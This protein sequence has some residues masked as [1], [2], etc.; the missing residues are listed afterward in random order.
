MNKKGILAAIAVLAGSAAVASFATISPGD[1]TPAPA[2]RPLVESLAIDPE[3]A[4]LA[5]PASYVREEQLHRGDTLAAF[6]ARLGIEETQIAQLAR[7]RALRAL[8]PGISVRAEVAADGSALSLSFL[9]GRD[10]LVTIAPEGDGFAASEA[11]APFET[12]VTMKSSSIRSS[13]FEA[14]D[15]AGV[16]DNIAMQLADVFAGD[17]DFYRDLRKGD[18][19]TVVYETYLLRGRPVR[20]GRLLAAEFV[21][22]GRALRAIHYQSGYYTPEGKNLR[23]AFLRYPLEFSRVSSGFG[24]RRHPIYGGWRAHKGIDYAAPMGTR[25]RAVADGVVAF[26]GLK[27]GYG[28]VVML[29][30]NGQ[31]STVYGHL[32]RIGVHP[33]ARVA[34]NDT[35]GFV[36]QTGWATGPHLHYEFRIAGQPRNPAAIAMPAAEPVPARELDAFATL[37]Q[38]LVAQLDLAA[39]ANL[40]LLE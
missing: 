35:I 25:V 16:P 23:K 6:L 15:A 36:G 39:S 22:Q 29:R 3:Q 34:Q 40:A 13:L 21:N 2:A 26:A 12:R 37:A 11:P 14:S 4:V 38:P 5:S 20:A 9:A 19:F 1:P 28:K 31:Y 18:R 8:H 10:M 30:H 33:G 32:S 24:M 17:V 7:L 27:G